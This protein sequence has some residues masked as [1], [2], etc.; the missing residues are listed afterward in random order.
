VTT[1]GAR[2]ALAAALA[3]LLGYQ[4]PRPWTVSPGAA[5]SDA[6]FLGFYPAEGSIR[7]SPDHA[8]IRFPDPAPGIPVRV[9]LELAG[10]RPRGAAAPLVRISTGGASTSARPDRRGET[11]HV[12]ATPS[13]IW[14]SD[15]VLDLDSE[16]FTPGAGDPRR[17]GVQVR[18]ARLVPLGGWPRRAPLAPV[19]GAALAASLA[20]LLAERAGARTR[21]AYALG[22]GLAAVLGLGPALAPLRA[23]IWVPRAAATLGLLVGGALLRPREARAIGDAVAGSVASLAAGFRALL[24]PE[25][26]LLGVLG[27]AGLVV[28]HRARPVVDFDIGSDRTAWLAHD[29]GAFDASDG[30]RFRTARGARLDLRDFGGGSTWRIDVTAA[31][32]GGDERDVEVARALDAGARARVGS[33]RWTKATLA[34]APGIGWR[35]GPLLSVAEGAPVP[36]RV[37]R[38]RIDRRGGWP[39]GRVAAGVAIASLLGALAFLT[40]GLSRRVSISAGALL[41]VAQDAALWDDPGVVIPFVARFAA[42]V[43]IAAL[44][45]ATITVAV[46]MRGRRADPAVIAAAAAGFVAWCSATMF[47]LY[48]G[49]HFLFHSAIAEEIWKGRFWI[50]YL[51][52]PGSMLS[53]QAQWGNVIVPHPCLY[54][55][56]VAPLA[57][58]GRPAFLLAEKGLL[59]LLFGSLVFVCAALAQRVAGGTAA[60]WSAVTFVALVPTYQLLGLGHLMT[61][62]GVWAS[63]LALLYLVGH[64]ARLHE[65]SVWRVAVLLFAFCFLSYFA[66]LLFTGLVLVLFLAT[67]HCLERGLARPLLSALVAATILAFGLYYAYWFWPF[68]SESLP[69]LVAGSGDAVKVHDRYLLSRLLSQPGKLDYSYGSLLVPLAG[70]VG[71]L[72]LRTARPRERRL[73]VLWLLILPIVTGM[74]LFFNFL[75]KHHY[76]V[77][78]PVAVGVGALLAR[79]AERGVPGRAAAVAGLLAI[80]WLGAGTAVQVAIGAIP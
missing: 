17:L 45:S 19:A 31:A 59:A 53:Q 14:N 2:V 36:L 63:S 29:F 71:L 24:C 70:L 34:P 13:G 27:T 72:R 58:L 55:T 11:I 48:R 77:M 52:Y 3:T 69:A 20:F 43:A 61:I 41:W 57:A 75:L 5:E 56:L 32:D 16:T 60:R 47:P 65:P 12:E 10:W 51:P 62:L 33:D 21:S 73:L 66:A 64:V 54:Q 9:D 44:L 6:V 25:M 22:L 4:W 15:L 40:A 1:R 37:D 49:G 26:A 67:L 50:Y 76:Y 80:V 28:A 46:G 68:L 18:S 8:Q 23:A 35:P 39:A 79:L 38:V 42:I 7:W 78:V 30:H 74:D